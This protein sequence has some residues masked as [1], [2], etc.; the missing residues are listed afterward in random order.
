MA[1]VQSA[2]GLDLGAHSLKAVVLRQRGSHVALVRAGTI[3][4]GELAFLDDSPRKDLRVAELLRLLRRQARIPGGIAGSGLSGRDYFPKYLHTPPAAP[5]KLRKIIEYEVTEDAASGAR[6]QTSDFW[7]LDLPTRA[8]EFTILLALAPNAALVRRLDLLRQVG[9]KSDGLTL[10]ALA[11]FN[12]YAH[13]KGEDLYNDK[14]TLLVDIGSRHLD[15][16]VQRNGKLLFLR[17]LTHGGQRFSESIQEEFHLPIAEAEARK[18][19]EGAIIPKHFDVAAEVDMGT[20]ESHLSATLLEPAQAI[21][22][23]LQA[24]LKYCQSQTRMPDLKIDEVVLAGRGARLR[25][26]TEFLAHRLR[27]PVGILDPLQR[28]ETSSLPPALRE[29]VLADASGYTVAIG[30]ALRQLAEPHLRPITLL[31]ESIRRR[32]AFFARDAFVYA[33]GLVFA[34][35]LAAMVYSSS[36]ASAKAQNDLQIEKSMTQEGLVAVQEFEAHFQ[37]NGQFAAQ[38]EALK[39]LFNTARRSDDAIALLKQRVPLQLRVDALQLASDSPMDLPSRNAPGKEPG[40]ATHL[41]I[42][43]TVAEKFEGKEIS[44]AAAKNIVDQFLTSLLGEK[45]LY[46]AGKVA[47]YPSFKATTEAKRVFKIILDFAT[48]FYGG[49][50]STKP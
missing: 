3:E 32:R 41:I 18:L 10:N 46:G 9:F 49:L 35:A 33:A 20:R 15:V 14:T 17:N 13:A 25:G 28:I 2:T 24:T 34:L 37:Q 39:L 21:C 1:K 27:L 50:G 5:Q 36:I 7:L 42:E 30:L 48:P 6:E 12:A 22:D 47:M 8:E 19:A 11:L 44:E 16:V 31:P 40:L 23:T 45:R 38:A 4:L 29:E 43:G 26:L